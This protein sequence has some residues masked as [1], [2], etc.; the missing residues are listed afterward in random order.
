MK[1]RALVFRSL[2]SLPVCLLGVAGILALASL[3]ALALPFADDDTPPDAAAAAPGGRSVRL[4]SVE[5]GVRVVLDGEVVADPALVNQP[6]FE[7]SQIIT[8]NDG[9]AEVQLEDGS[10]ARLSPNTTLTFS[11]MQAQGTSTKTEIVV[12]GGLAYFELQPSNNQ[13]SLRVNYGRTG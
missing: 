6:L 8:A 4:S 7:G 5:G 11:V 9:Q 12:N 2:F 10:V 3:P 13:H 1:Y